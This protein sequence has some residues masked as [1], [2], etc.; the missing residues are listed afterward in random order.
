MSWSSPHGWPT[1]L[2]SGDPVIIL[3]ALLVALT[4]PLALHFYFFTTSGRAAVVPTFLLLGPSG[5]G[6]TSLVSLVRRPKADGFMQ[7]G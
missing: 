5:A 3:L 2:F 4:L 6:K 1:R 7:C